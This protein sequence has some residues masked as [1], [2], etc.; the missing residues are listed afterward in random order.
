MP[1]KCQDWPA[2]PDPSTAQEADLTSVLISGYTI[3]MFTK[4]HRYRIYATG[5][6]M[7]VIVL[8]SLVEAVL[9]WLA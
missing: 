8:A 6:G 4:F 7:L 2:Y 9:D 5:V 1:L 3:G